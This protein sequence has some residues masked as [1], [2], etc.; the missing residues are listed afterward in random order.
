MNVKVDNPFSLGAFAIILDD[1]NR[2]LLCHRRDFDL[3]NLPGGAIE[4][5]ELPTEAAIRETKEE[6]GLDVSIERLVGIY[7]NAGKNDLVFTF[8]C[9]IIGGHLSTTDESD[10]CKYFEIKDIPANTVPR[11]VGRI[12][13]AYKNSLQPIIRRQTEPSSREMLRKT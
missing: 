1:Q 6:T 3:W 5:N 9:N 7:S 2:V 11:H 8:V 4:K 13:D 10:S 12:H